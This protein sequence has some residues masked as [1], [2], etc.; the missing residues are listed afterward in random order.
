M[1]ATCGARAE[2]TCLRRGAAAH[3]PLP[4]EARYNP[5]KAAG[6]RDLAGD[7]GRGTCARGSPIWGVSARQESPG[8]AGGA[9]LGACCEEPLRL[10][11][12]PSFLSQEVINCKAQNIKGECEFK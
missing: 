8:V 7:P 4:L 9:K 12:P 5:P 1:E 2:R 11:D 6:I 3:P 10:S